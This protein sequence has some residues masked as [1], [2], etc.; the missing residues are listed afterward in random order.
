MDIEQL[1]TDAIASQPVSTR[2]CDC[3]CEMLDFNKFRTWSAA[4]GGV[5]ISNNCFDCVKQN[6]KVRRDK[7]ANK[8]PD[9]H[10]VAY[11]RANWRSSGIEFSEEQDFEY[12]YARYMAATHCEATGR[13]FDDTKMGCKCLD[14]DHKTGKPRGII[15]GIANL[16]LGKVDDD[17]DTLAKLQNYLEITHGSS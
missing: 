1:L 8:F 6:G 12:W 2:K 11:T 13:E 16:I 7:W 14:H 15:C 17:V 10:K 9:R 3:C 5:R 4:Y